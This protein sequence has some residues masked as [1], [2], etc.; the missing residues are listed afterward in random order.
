MSTKEKIK[1]SATKLFAEHGYSGM[2]IKEI[3]KEVGIKP[4]SIYAFFKGK[5]DIFLAIYRDALEGH[6][7]TVESQFN[8]GCSAKSQ[9]YSILK[10]AVDFQF[11]EDL[12]TKLLIRLMI[13]PP[14]FLKEDISRR[15]DE[16]EQNEYKILCEIFKHGIDKGEVKAL[17]CHELAIS[18]QCLMDGVF[19]QM[20]R[21]N[22]EEIYKRLNVIFDQFW[23]GISQ[24]NG[25]TSTKN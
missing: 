16:M 14:D 8:S 17:D 9:L 2:T 25:I 6:L 23:I 22:Q 5:D 24:E 21:H 3:A 13:S 11:R 18:F 10:S 1:E 19:W 15:F 7:L 4:P 12:K 20:Q